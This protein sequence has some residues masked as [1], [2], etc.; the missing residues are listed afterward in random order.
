MEKLTF[1]GIGPK[2]GRI[3][4]PYAAITIALTIIFPTIFTFGK[5]LQQPFM[6]A[7]IILLAIALIFYFSTL[8]LMLPGIRG[9]K[10][11]TTGAY[12]LCRNPLYSALINLF[13]P[14]LALLLNSWLIF[15]VSLAGYLLI[16]KYIH[17]EEELLDRIFGDK[18]KRYHEQTPL[19]FPNPFP[20]KK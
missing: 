7:G 8:R 14:G 10:L 13:V 17:E 5:F 3:T 11:I 16:R 15:T 4:L 20:G 9:N 12:R 1:L 19:I 18:Y 2:I 6:V